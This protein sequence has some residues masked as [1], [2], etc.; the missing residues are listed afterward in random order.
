MASNERVRRVS[1]QIRR[2]LVTILPEAIF[3]EKIAFVS[4]T[5]INLSRDFKHATTY[6]TIIGDK[7]LRQTLVDLLN[8]HRGEI[9]HLLAKRLTTRT[10]PEM[11]FVYDDSVEYGARMEKLLHDIVEEDKI[12]H[13]NLQDNEN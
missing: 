2:E 6:V 11:T 1:E 4:V 10:V 7:V 9:R 8:R 13:G 3:H 12:R 5:G